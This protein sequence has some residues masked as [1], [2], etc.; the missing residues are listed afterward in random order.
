MGWSEGYLDYSVSGY[1]EY[2]V[3]GKQEEVNEMYFFFEKV[4]F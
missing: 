3:F 1:L 4:Y 2:L